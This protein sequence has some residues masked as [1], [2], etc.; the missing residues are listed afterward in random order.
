M[1]ATGYPGNQKEPQMRLF[2]CRAHSAGN[3]AFAVLPEAKKRMLN[4]V[5]ACAPTFYF[6][7]LAMSC[8]SGVISL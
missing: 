8:C 2:F 6:Q 3:D 4:A 7:F 5:S 1:R